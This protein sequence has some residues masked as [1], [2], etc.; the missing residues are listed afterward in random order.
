MYQSLGPL[1][2]IYRDIKGLGC[3]VHVPDDW[4]L[5]ALVLGIVAQLLGKY[6]C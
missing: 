2:E 4:M 6:I 1:K 3:R 5:G